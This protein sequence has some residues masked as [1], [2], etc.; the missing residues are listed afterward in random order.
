M[1]SLWLLGRTAAAAEPTSEDRRLAGSTVS[2][3]R[4]RLLPAALP[5]GGRAADDDD[6]T[7]EASNVVAAAARDGGGAATLVYVQLVHVPKT[8]GSTLQVWH[9]HRRRRA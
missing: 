2:L 9:A 3:S 6:P 1:L 8:G 5:G 7:L 4:P